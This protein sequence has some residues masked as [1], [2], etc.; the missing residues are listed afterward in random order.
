MELHEFTEV[1]EQL[2][3]AG[4]LILVDLRMKISLGQ[5]NCCE[6]NCCDDYC[7][8]DNCCGDNSCDE[9]EDLPGRIWT[10]LPW[11]ASHS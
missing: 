5:L 4:L 1:H 10:H 6:E 8:D 11:K 3:V 2:V 9:N 7:C